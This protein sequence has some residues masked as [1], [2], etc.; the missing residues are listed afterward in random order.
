MLICL[1]HFLVEFLFGTVDLGIIVTKMCEYISY[2]GDFRFAMRKYYFSLSDCSDLPD[3]LA[4]SYLGLNEFYRWPQS[5]LFEC[6]EIQKRKGFNDS[7]CLFFVRVVFDRSVGVYVVK[8]CWS[9][10]MDHVVNLSSIVGHVRFEANLFVDERSQL[11]NFD[12]IGYTGLQ[13]KTALCRLFS[14]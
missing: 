11:A 5:I 4:N 7:D 2:H 1:P 13:S 6:K 12:K 10:H 14:N 9:S 3:V 8:I